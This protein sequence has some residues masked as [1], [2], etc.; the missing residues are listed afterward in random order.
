MNPEAGNLTICECFF[1]N[2]LVEN[3]FQSEISPLFKR[4]RGL[5][6]PAGRGPPV[7]TAMQP[8]FSCT[9]VDGTDYGGF[10]FGK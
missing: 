7:P 8:T 5:P 3:P 4:R 6:S 1:D 10:C 9:G 2:D